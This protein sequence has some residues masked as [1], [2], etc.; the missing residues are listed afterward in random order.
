MFICVNL[1]YALL[2]T[3]IVRNHFPFATEIFY[4]F[5]IYVCLVYVYHH[6]FSLGVVVISPIRTT[7]YAERKRETFKAVDDL[8]V[9]CALVLFLPLVVW[10]LA[11]WISTH[12]G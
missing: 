4:A 1:L 2:L 9:Y 10:C 5:A 3:R 11:F 8:G 7:P 12:A 6:F